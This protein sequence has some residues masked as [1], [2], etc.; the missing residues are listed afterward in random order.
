VSRR[1]RN[2]NVSRVMIGTPV[3]VSASAAVGSFSSG[4]CSPAIA[5]D[6]ASQA[7]WSSIVLASEIAFQD[8]TCRVIAAIF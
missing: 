8:L 1:P 5:T 4:T 6:S 3:N 2:P 7:R